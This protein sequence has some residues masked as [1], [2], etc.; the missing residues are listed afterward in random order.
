LDGFSLSGPARRLKILDHPQFGKLTILGTAEPALRPAGQWNQLE[1]VA[2][3]GVVTQRLNGV[4]VNEA[5]DCETAAGPILLTSEGD[6]IQF[7]DIQ[8]KTP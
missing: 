2:Q 3:G 5:R 1:I 4:L 8:L 7:R 6:S